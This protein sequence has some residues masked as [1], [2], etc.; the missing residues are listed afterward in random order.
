[1]KG[2]KIDFATVKRKVRYCFDHQY[3]LENSYVF[4]WECDYF[5]ISASGYAYEVEIKMSRQDFK[6]EFKNK[7]EKHKRLANGHKDLYIMKGYDQTELMKRSIA[8]EIGLEIS[9]HQ[10]GNENVYVNTH[11]P[12]NI[13]EPIVPHRFYFACPKGLIDKK[14]IPDYAGLLYVTETN[15]YRVK[16]APFIH[17]R[18]LNLDAVLKR[19]FYYS[20]LDMK[21]KLHEAKSD[22]LFLKEQY[23][24]ITTEER[25][26]KQLELI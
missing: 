25:V 5:G 16:E 23:K 7:T 1:M 26:A 8:E 6:N 9:K 18:K 12:I 2:N 19:K 22:M 14:E 24:I 4:A 3:R 21:L 17:K 11:T 20:Y 10:N 15:I 13:I